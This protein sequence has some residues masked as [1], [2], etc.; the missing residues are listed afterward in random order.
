ML[1]VGASIDTVNNQG[2]TALHLAVADGNLEAVKVL[3]AHYANQTI[4]DNHGQT[5]IDEAIKTNHTDSATYLKEHH[6]EHSLHAT[7]EF[8]LTKEFSKIQAIKL[9][10]VISE[11]SVI[12]V[13]LENGSAQ[14]INTNPIH[15]TTFVQESILPV[16]TVETVL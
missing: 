1:D 11:S 8:P 13:L 4:H 15:I 2:E 7:N 6:S 16:I 9:N 10:D 14:N 5:P 3:V 12:D